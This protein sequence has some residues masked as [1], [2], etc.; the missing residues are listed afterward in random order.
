MHGYLIA[1][2]NL[3]NNAG[4]EHVAIIDCLDF[5]PINRRVINAMIV[6]AHGD[7]GPVAGRVRYQYLYPEYRR[8]WQFTYLEWT[9]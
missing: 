8:N 5:D 2:D 1:F 3:G 9:Q 4:I 7:A 6:H